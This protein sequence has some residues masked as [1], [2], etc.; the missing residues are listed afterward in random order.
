MYQSLKLTIL[1]SLIAFATSLPSPSHALSIAPGCPNGSTAGPG[2]KKCLGSAI[3]AYDRCMI[4]I[5]QGY[6]NQSYSGPTGFIQVSGSPS[7]PSNPPQPM[8]NCIGEYE[9]AAKLCYTQHCTSVRG[10]PLRRPA[11]PNSAF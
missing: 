8:R 1:V 11:F 7:T 2:L 4:E 10:A 6:Q 9:M 5:S 3:A